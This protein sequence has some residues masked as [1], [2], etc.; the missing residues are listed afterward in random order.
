VS[1][2]GVMSMG[3]QSLSAQL[4]ELI[5]VNG[6]L[7][8]ALLWIGRDTRIADMH[9]CKAW[10]SVPHGVFGPARTF[11]RGLSGGA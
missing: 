2:L 3:V 6:S 9:P 11:R 4:V 5:S 8:V 1:R 7:R 10:R